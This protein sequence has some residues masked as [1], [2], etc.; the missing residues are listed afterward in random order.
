MP[1]AVVCWPRRK[2]E[3]EEDK[4]DRLDWGLPATSALSS[5]RCWLPQQSQTTLRETRGVWQAAA[6]TGH[7]CG[8]V[9]QSPGMALTCGLPTHARTPFYS[10]LF[11][12]PQ[13]VTCATCGG[14]D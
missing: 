9:P 13:M 6:R 11:E 12:C 2:S 3:A 5:L 4:E 10:G 7:V 14:T 1:G 8:H